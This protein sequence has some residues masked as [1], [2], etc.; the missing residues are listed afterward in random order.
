VGREKDCRSL[1][2]QVYD[3]VP[4]LSGTF[5]VD[6]RRRFIKKQDL[7][8]VDERSS[9]RQFAAHSF[10][11]RF[12][13]A[14]AGFSQFELLQELTS[15]R[16]TLFLA[17]AV[18]SSTETEIVKP[19]H[20]VVQIALV[21]HDPHQGLCLLRLL[22]YI[23]TVNRNV[24]C[25]GTRKPDDHV[26]GRCLPGSVRAQQAEDFTATNIKGNIVHGS[27]VSVHLLQI[28]DTDHLH[29]LTTP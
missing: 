2:F 4:D 3:H 13:R 11:I 14:F 15:S 12:E 17:H 16:L 26:D 20:F 19:V 7:R 21:R 18:Q 22:S 28:S 1:P 6:T 5:D 8:R 27:N 23:D 25:R 9:N 24:A 29:D 10:G